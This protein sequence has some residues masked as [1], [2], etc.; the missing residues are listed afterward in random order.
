MKLTCT[1][2]L[3]ASTALAQIVVKPGPTPPSQPASQPA[4]GP[5]SAQSHSTTH[6]A[7]T[8]PCD[9]LPVLSPKIPAL[10][11]GAPCAR[12]LFVMST[13]PQANFEYISPLADPDLR[14]TL[15]VQSVRFS[16]DYIDTKVGAGPLA[17]PHM[18]YTVHYTGYLADGTKF[19]SSYD[20]PDH[21]PFTF[22]YGQHKVILGWDTGLDGM[23][24]G[25]ER[26][27]FIPWELAYGPSGK[28]PT[29]PAKA[30][31]IFDV[32]L[33]SQSDKDPSAPAA[34]APPATPAVPASAPA[35]ASPRAPAAPKD[36]QPKAVEKAK[37]PLSEMSAMEVAQNPAAYGFKKG[38]SMALSPVPGSDL[39]PSKDDQWTKEDEDGKLYILTIHYDKNGKIV[40]AK[41]GG[42]QP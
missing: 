25:G 34:A 36:T 21:A 37:K 41:W 32:E 5:A 38:G 17:A 3:F 6:A 4:A 18:W 8:H 33:L 15:N 7:A 13:V 39:E 9:K 22:P 19:D 23:R 31:L 16:L 30:E 20:H 12:P 24:I 26:R 40:S 35:A 42:F 11:A 28:P 14:E 1:L 27:L 10:P 2:F 29:I